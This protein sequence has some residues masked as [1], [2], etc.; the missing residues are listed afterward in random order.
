[1]EERELL[2]AK[3]QVRLRQLYETL[4][5]QTEKS[6]R[7]REALEGIITDISHQIKIPMANI[8]MYHTIIAKRN[9]SP[10]Q[11]EE[12]LSS[13]DGQVDRLD[14][15][16][17][18]MIKMS[19]MEVGMIKVEPVYQRIMP[20]VEQAVCQ[21]ALKAEQK[22]IDIEVSCED[23]IQA[24]FDLNWTLEA[25]ENILDNAVKYTHEQGRI[26]IAADVTDFFVR[27]KVEDNG[28]GITE[29]YYTSIFKRFFRGAEVRHEEGMG[30]GLYLAQEIVRK[31]K[32]YISV[33]S[34]EG[35]G[36]VFSMYLTAEA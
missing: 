16:M 30:V 5:S 18:S 14:T 3:V 21:I 8:R 32:G 9:L 28:I 13:V 36:S 1:M 6:F 22:Q 19:R 29:E 23:W 10:K 12:F 35:E 25:L 11:Q 27:I 2:M 33:E 7:D 17:Q 20:L 26:R 24:V 31:Q 34:E 15:L 4:Q